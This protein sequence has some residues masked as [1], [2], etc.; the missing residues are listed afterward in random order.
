M[1]QTE[2]RSKR[3]TGADDLAAMVVAAA[4]E[5]DGAALRYHDGSDWQDMSYEEL[6]Q[7]TREIAGGLID[8]G[9]EAGDRV[10]IFSET[11]YE[12]TLVDFAVWAAGA[13]G[14]PVYETSSAEQV[15]WILTDSAV[16][17]LVVE[18]AQHAAT[19]ASTSR[20]MV[21]SGGPSGRR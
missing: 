11:R 14:V 1:S 10:A 17:L 12:W 21:I 7:A 16:S 19:V 2:A 20:G 15:H 5:N 8:L 13:V 9:I 6:G 3:G 18:T 4:K